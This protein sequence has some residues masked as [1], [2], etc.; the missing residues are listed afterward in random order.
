MNE[1]KRGLA[2]QT[3]LDGLLCEESHGGK[4]LHQFMRDAMA[5]SQIFR[6]V[7]RNQHVAFIVLPYEDL[8]RKI[9]RAGR[10]REHHWSACL[11]AAED[12]QLRGLHLQSGFLRLSAVIDEGKEGHS[13]RF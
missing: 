2:G 9:D 6:T 5:P 13:L 8:Q 10:S 1:G 3:L 12:E 11:G 7:I 4:V